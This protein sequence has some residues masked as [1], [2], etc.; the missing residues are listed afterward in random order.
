MSIES[1]AALA[2]LNDPDVFV[3]GVP[4]ETFAHWRRTDP[5]HLTKHPE[6][7][8]YWSVTSYDEVVLASRDGAAV[9][10]RARWRVHVRDGRGD[11][12]AAEH[13]DADDGPA[14]PHAVPAARE[15]RVHA[16]QHPLAR[17]VHRPDRDGDRR[18]R[19]RAG[20]V[21]LRDRP[22]RRA[23][24]AGDRRDDGR[25][26]AGPEADLRLVEQDDRQR[27][28]G[29][30]DGRGRRGD[31]DGRAVRVQPRAG[32]RAARPTASRTSSPR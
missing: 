22:R 2:D 9:L 5:V 20:R 4:H 23:A 17:G 14:A 32:R 26:A 21:R 16:A 6:G 3:R 24:A 31:R 8:S 19:D 30:R 10:E 25:P 13:A 28:P 29:V 27:G 11:V 7:H 18:Q 1:P 12:G 15:P